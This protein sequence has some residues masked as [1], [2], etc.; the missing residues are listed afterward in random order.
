MFAAG[1][2]AAAWHPRFERYVR[3]EHWDNAREQ[4]RAAA[5]NILGAQKQYDRTPYFYS[6]QFD[7]GM[8]YRG[9][10]HGWDDVV[11]PWRP[12]EA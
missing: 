1:D 3:V 5:A 2:I 10:A 8:E 6:D 7:L 4:G 11:D 9:F 12:G